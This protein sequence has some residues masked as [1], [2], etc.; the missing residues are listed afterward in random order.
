MSEA[1]NQS[2]VFEAT[3]LPGDARVDRK[4]GKAG[5]I[6]GARAMQFG[7]L[8]EGDSRPFFV[9]D[10]TLSQVAAFVNR[11]PSGLKMRFSHRSGLDAHIGKAANASVI[12]EGEGS[13]V[14]ID[15]SMSKAATRTPNGDLAGYVMDLADESPEDFGLSVAGTQFDAAAM[16]SAKREDG[17]FPIRFKG[18]KAIDLASDPAATSGL[19]EIKEGDK[20]S[21]EDHAA[22]LIDTH[23]DGLSRSDIEARF[24]EFT[25]AYFDDKGNDMPDTDNAELQ[26]ATDRIAELEA[27]LAKH[28]EIVEPEEESTE[29]SESEKSARATLKARAELTALCKLAKVDDDIRDLMIEANFDRKEAQEFLKV[30]GYLSASN[31]AISEGGTDMGEK[32][33]TPEDEFGA[34][35]DQFT[36]VYERQGITRDEFIA[37][38]MIDAN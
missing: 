34:E 24:S 16:R 3:G 9:D 18:L 30:S 27:E 13:Y 7:P 37:S 5:M 28:D 35:F 2:P 22:W 26:A 33:K 29:L 11:Q 23:L 8:S 1:F 36:D 25:T 17:L 4:A 32:K 10:T 31:P 20:V 21:F 19:F 15:A 38:R 12:G 6:Y 14:A